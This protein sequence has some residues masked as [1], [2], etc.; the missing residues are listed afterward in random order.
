MIA[1]E[2]PYAIMDRLKAQQNENL[3]FQSEYRTFC[4]LCQDIV[5]KPELQRAL[6]QLMPSRAPFILAYREKP[7]KRQY[8]RLTL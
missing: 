1:L 2:G 8:A 3:P 4:E 6:V 7:L 5:T